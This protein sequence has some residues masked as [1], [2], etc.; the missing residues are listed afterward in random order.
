MG[1]VRSAEGASPVVGVSKKYLYSR[2]ESDRL[3]RSFPFDHPQSTRQSICR[4][5]S[6]CRGIR[7]LFA[8]LLLH[9]WP[10]SIV[11]RLR[12]SHNLIE[13]VMTLSSM[14]SSD[15]MS[16]TSS[17]YD[18][19]TDSKDVSYWTARSMPLSSA[20]DSNQSLHHDLMLTSSSRSRTT[21]L[22]LT[23]S[24]SAATLYLPPNAAIPSQTDLSYCS[25]NKNAGPLVNLSLASSTSITCSGTQSS[26]PLSP[27]YVLN[28]H[29]STRPRTPKQFFASTFDLAA[30][31]GIPTT[32]PPLPTIRSRRS[33]SVTQSP[34]HTA[35]AS[36]F[37]AL[38][39][40]YLNMLSQKPESISAPSSAEMPGV[41]VSPADLLQPAGDDFEGLIHSLGKSLLTLPSIEFRSSPPAQS[42]TSLHHVSP[43]EPNEYLTSPWTPSLDQFGESP[44]ESPGETPL[45]DFLST[46]LIPDLD[47]PTLN[48]LLYSQSPVFGSPSDG[49]QSSKAPSAVSLDTS[50]LLTF[51]ASPGTPA[52]DLSHLASPTDNLSSPIWK[53]VDSPATRN[54]PDLNPPRRSTATGTRKN[55]TA[56]SLVPLEAPTQPRKYVTPSATSKKE[57]PVI[58]ARKRARQQ[59]LDGEE[60]GFDEL[61]K[62]NATEVEQIEW[63]RRQ[64]TLAARKS[65]KRKLMHQRALEIQVTDLTEDREKWRQRALTLQGILQAHGIPFAE[66]QE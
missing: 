3:H 10:T 21:G 53:S 44:G 56:E 34:S 50:K 55:I 47:A 16:A 41:T 24:S 13:S 52:L 54:T 29:S 22:P 25:L 39:A 1:G 60:E 26:V 33:V 14:D 12:S 32:L 17:S 9:S 38:K 65:R 15:M 35:L 31:Y 57:M 7:E 11:L 30:H 19:A 2:V 58:F 6:P 28:N 59:M 49:F 43:F 42:T 63:K 23:V 66:F 5:S 4:V 27:K 62:P 45:N 40:S 64:N 37:S 8:P 36:D 18:A 46:P 61:L 48:E 51:P 20:M